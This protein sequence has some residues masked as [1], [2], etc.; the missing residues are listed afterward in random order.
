MAGSFLKIW[1]KLFCIFLV[2]CMPALNVIFAVTLAWKEGLTSIT[3]CSLDMELLELNIL[4]WVGIGHT[5]ML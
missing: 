2:A 3:A 1:F 5:S 4:I